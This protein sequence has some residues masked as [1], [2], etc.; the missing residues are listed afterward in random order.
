M[1][2][3][4]AILRNYIHTTVYKPQKRANLQNLHMQYIANDQLIC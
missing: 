1:A 2:N 4:Q 3:I